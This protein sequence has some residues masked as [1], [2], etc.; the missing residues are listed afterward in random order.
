MS[1]VRAP[2]IAHLSKL[3]S[4]FEAILLGIIQGLTE[5]L[6]VSSSGHLTLVQTLL[7][8]EHLDRYILFDLVCHMGTLCSIF[9][10]FYQPIISLFKTNRAQLGQIVIGTLPLFPL[11]LILK[12]IKAVFDSPEYLGYFFLITA[13][14]LWLG[15]RF[16]STESSQSLQTKKWRD[17][18]I[19]GLFQAFAIL[20]GV[21]RSGSTISG[22]RLLGWGFQDALRFSFLLAIPAIL[23]GTVL[24]AGQLILKPQDYP[25]ANLDFVQ[26]GAGFLASFVFGYGALRWLMSMGTGNK[27]IYFVWYCLLIG[28][29]SLWYFNH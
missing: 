24:E 23:G 19:I 29:F 11:V 20:P 2:S 5:F 22:A 18:W 26:Y 12:P 1:R 3:M 9:F 14:L 28:F 16:G 13:V 21:S 7:G 4:T 8:L 6:P 17:P 27:F 10:I 25:H 15:I